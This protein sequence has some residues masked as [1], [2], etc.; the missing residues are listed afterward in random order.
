MQIRLELMGDLTKEEIDTSFSQLSFDKI[1]TVR[2]NRFQGQDVL[3]YLLT[4]GGGV[5][6]VQFVKFIKTL[7]EKNKTKS[8]KIDD[9]EI[10]GFSYDD[11]MDLLDKILKNKKELMK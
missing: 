1:D 4:F 3:I 8:V 9:V 7:C 6:I 5:S 10:K 11:T 2:V